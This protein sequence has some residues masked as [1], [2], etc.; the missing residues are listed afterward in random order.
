MT[1]PYRSFTA[2]DHATVED[3]VVSGN[4]VKAE[5]SANHIAGAYLGYKMNQS[6]IGW[7]RW[8]HA[9]ARPSAAD[10]A[11][12]A[13][14]DQAIDFQWTIDVSLVV[15]T[16]TATWFDLMVRSALQGISI[17]VGEK[18]NMATITGQVYDTGK[19]WSHYPMI[20]GGDAYSTSPHIHI[21]DL[22][23][24]VVIYGC[25]YKAGFG[26]SGNMAQLDHFASGYLNR[27]GNNDASYYGGQDLKI[28]T[29][30]REVR[31][32]Y[33]N[34]VVN[35]L[36]RYRVTPNGGQA[37]VITGLG[38]NNDDTE[39][40]NAA[41][42]PI[43]DVPPGGS[44]KDYVTKIELVGTHGEGT[45][46]LGRLGGPYIPAGMVGTYVIE[47]NSQ[48]TIASTPAIPIGTY[49]IRLSKDYTPLLSAIPSAYAGDWR[50]DVGT[51]EM[52]AGTRLYLIV[53][54]GGKRRPLPGVKWEWPIVKH[55]APID[56]RAP[57]IFYDGRILSLSGFTRSVSS[58][59]GTYLGSDADIKLSNV[60]K[61]FS[62]L[63]FTSYAKNMGVGI[64]YLWSDEP[65]GSK[66]SVSKFVVDDY[67]LQGPTFSAKLRDIGSKYF[68]K[69]LPEFRCTLAEFPNIY[70]KAVNAP[71]PDILGKF[72]FTTTDKPGA[73]KAVY[74][75]TANYVYLAAR[76]SLFA[77]TEVY[78]A[79]VLK[80]DAVDYSISYDGLGQTLI[81]FA[82]SQGDNEVT[83]NCEGYSLPAWDSANGYVQN[84]A[85]V[86]EFFLEYLVGVPVAHIDMASFDTLAAWFDAGGFDE[87]GK[88]ALTGE[89]SC[90]EY[91]RQ[92]LYTF[93]TLAAFTI[94][95]KWQI[96][97]KDY[98]SLS[99]SKTVW[100]QLDCADHPLREYINGTA[101]NRIRAAWNLAPAP[102]VYQ[103]GDTFTNPSSITILGS[104]MEPSQQ[105]M[106]PWTDSAAWIA[107]RAAEELA[108][109]AF[110]DNKFKFT[111]PI[112]WLDQIDLLDNLELQDLFGVN[113]TGSGE[114]GRPMYIDSL[115]VNFDNMTIELTCP[116]L[117]W[118]LTELFIL[119]DPAI[120]SNWAT[121][122]AEDRV[123]GYL[124]DTTGVF[125]GGAPGKKL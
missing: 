80:S 45:Y 123:Y 98:A 42:N 60:D 104:T 5:W 46:A 68:Q 118:I 74:V 84:P 7:E 106:F 78:S 79:G 54:G 26:P 125:A 121:A 27:L 124:S 81:T 114:V 107:I 99:T 6:G 72:S 111:L 50:A 88:L 69:K 24:T 38:F 17:P 21:A 4:S 52:T 9:V 82:S 22:P 112:A 113:P 51:G 64:Y 8:R 94:D 11:I 40:T 115:T 97:R 49:E 3:L 91:F 47:S 93:G 95:G 100:A 89:E 92:L 25:P 76:G 16:A 13:G 39:I 73:I 85:R 101:F 59:V 18:P 19:D 33:F 103:G 10:F 58:G 15:L 36:S 71:K 109:Y 32:R 34:P 63:L 23:K 37:V 117:T 12:L 35:S 67:S 110:G 70:E 56:M 2:I 55:Y 1:I 119:G 105:P 122:G 29:I 77:V 102:G 44:W 41:N 20:G 61:E 116:D 96:I 75:D 66:V 87:I 86:I 48:I 90:E 108:R 30:F 65:E 28:Q 62:S 14:A 120:A 43:S 53:G 83:F 31:V 57:L